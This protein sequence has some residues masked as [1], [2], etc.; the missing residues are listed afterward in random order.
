MSTESLSRFVRSWSPWHLRRAMQRVTERSGGGN[1]CESTVDFY[2][3]RP[4][5]A[6]CRT[7]SGKSFHDDTICDGWCD[8]CVLAD[9]LDGNRP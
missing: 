1:R 6:S 8:S 5:H 9:A 3:G 2:N 4:H 7:D